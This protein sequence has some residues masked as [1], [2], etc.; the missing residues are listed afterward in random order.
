MIDWVYPWAIDKFS[1]SRQLKMEIMDALRSK[2]PLQNEKFRIPEP[3]ICKA[4]ASVLQTF[5]ELEKNNKT[6]WVLVATNSIFLLQTFAILVPVTMALTK[7][8]KPYNIDVDTLIELF[9][10]PYPRNDFEPDPIGE[11]L[12]RA[13]HSG[14]LVWERFNTKSI[15]ASKFISRFTKFLDGRADAKLCTLF[16]CNYKGSF[17]KNTIDWLFKSIEETFGEITLGYLEEFAKFKNFR[18]SGKPINFEDE[19]I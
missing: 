19:E 5:A 17:T 14:I 2:Y 6:P 15:A 12:C 10:R 8:K 3:R 18:V 13:E 16:L 11:E 4:V 1:G 7:H 9:R